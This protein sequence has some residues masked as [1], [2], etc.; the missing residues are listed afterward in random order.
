MGR[1]RG[2]AM[3]RES[4]Y[5]R[6]DVGI[7]PTGENKPPQ[8]KPKCH[9]DQDLLNEEV[10]KFQEHVRNH[11]EDTSYTGSPTLGNLLHKLV[12]NVLTSRYFN[13]YSME[14]KDEMRMKC[15]Y[16]CMRACHRMRTDRGGRL[17]MAYFSTTV[18]HAC[19]N[20]IMEYYKEVNRSYEYKKSVL[21]E[22]GC[23]ERKIKELI[24]EWEV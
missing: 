5:F 10:R 18:F 1:E 2:Y 23:S 14:M 9:I 13:G 15:Y 11:P 16:H 20:A 6:G 19:Q 4:T 22:M 3:R 24:G 21:Q 8:R 12:E 17:C 7:N